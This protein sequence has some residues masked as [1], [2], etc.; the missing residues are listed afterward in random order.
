MNTDRKIALATFKADMKSVVEFTRQYKKAFKEWQRTG[1]NQMLDVVTTEWSK[2]SSCLYNIQTNTSINT[3]PDYGIVLIR[4][5]VRHMHIAYSLLKGRT[6]DQ[7]EKTERSVDEDRV[8]FYLTK[9]VKSAEIVNSIQ[10]KSENGFIS[11]ILNK[12]KELCHV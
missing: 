1:S 8:K 6:L 12:V 11:G 4:K 2:H 5:D 7:I 3:W 10:I 9:Y